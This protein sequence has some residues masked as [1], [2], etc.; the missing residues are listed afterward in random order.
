MSGLSHTQINSERKLS[1][2]FQFSEILGFT[3]EVGGA[4]PS[5]LSLRLQ[6]ISNG[7]IKH[8]NDGVTFASLVYSVPF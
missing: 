6:H 4:S 8:P 3:L 5:S 7:G 2:G 1:T